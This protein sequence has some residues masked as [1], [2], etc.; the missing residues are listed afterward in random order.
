M[1]KKKKEFDPAIPDL[2]NKILNLDDVAVEV[3]LREY[4]GQC[5]NT[6]N[7][8]CNELRERQANKT[9]SAME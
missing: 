7:D 5:R 8:N 3:T 4:L 6:Y 1:G 9:L 2:R